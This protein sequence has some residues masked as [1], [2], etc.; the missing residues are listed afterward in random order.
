MA[1]WFAA[2]RRTR[3]EFPH[4]WRGRMRKTLADSRLYHAQFGGSHCPRARSAAQEARSPSATA[5]N[6][7]ARAKQPSPRGHLFVS[8]ERAAR[9]APNTSRKKTHCPLKTAPRLAAP[10]PNSARRPNSTARWRVGLGFLAAALAKPLGK[11]VAPSQVHSPTVHAG[12][13]AI[14]AIADQS[15]RATPTAGASRANAEPLRAETIRAIADP[16]HA[17][18]RR[19][20][21]HR[22]STARQRMS[23][24]A[25]ERS[26]P[27]RI[28]LTH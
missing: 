25:D 20:P 26:A 4:P 22:G 15:T 7:D 13:R 10:Q 2:L 17:L 1:S 5:A 27:S 8:A 3:Q 14:R 11:A 12:Q 28:H 16:P 9:F 18:M 19:A 21:R 24:V 23:T 6:V